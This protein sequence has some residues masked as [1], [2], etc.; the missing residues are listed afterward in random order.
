MKKKKVLGYGYRIN[1]IFL[2]HKLSAK[3]AREIFCTIF[4]KTQYLG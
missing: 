2:K 4:L 1:E 3:I